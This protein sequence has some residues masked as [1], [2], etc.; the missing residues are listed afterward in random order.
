MKKVATVS[1]FALKALEIVSAPKK[2]LDIR[3]RKEL[4]HLITKN[5]DCSPFK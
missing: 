5:P 4:K 3:N 1:S 2:K